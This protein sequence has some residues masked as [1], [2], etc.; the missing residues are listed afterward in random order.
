[1]KIQWFKDI[2]KK[3]RKLILVGDVG[4]TNTNL[5]VA[6]DT[7]GK[8]DLILEVVFD[9]S[10]V[11]DFTLCVKKTMEVAREKHPNVSFDLCCIS[12]AGPVKDNFCK[13]T[14]QS[15]VIDGNEIQE[16]L[17]VPTLIINDFSAI[18]FGLPLLDVNS[19]QQIEVLTRPDGSSPE[20]QGDLRVVVGAGTGLGVGFLAKMGDR[21]RAFPSEGGHM[22]F[23]DFDED[24]RGFKAWIME[25]IDLV[26]EY[27]MGISGMGIKNLFYYFLEKE[28]LKKDDPVVQAILREADVNKPAA[29]SKAA[30][31]HEGCHRVFVT[32]VKMYA[33]LASS[34]ASFLL[35]RGGFYL[36]GGISGKNLEIFT[37]DHLF[38]KTFEQH[39]NPNILRVLQEIPIYVI[40]DY[41]ISLYGAANAALSLMV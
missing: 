2:D 14:N 36:A 13:M 28:V 38:V 21:W 6:G 39:C 3:Y 27:E 30:A 29:I 23:A 37:K 1:M 7:G 25:T 5:G 40:K 12:G 41:S 31:T 32:F 19:P 24:T 20:P 33:R 9:S 4:G 18:S 26:P 35:P 11:T 17:G 22:D 8:I 10:T 16:T 15:W 34:V